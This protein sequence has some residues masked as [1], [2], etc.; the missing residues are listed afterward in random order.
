MKL[1]SM[2]VENIKGCELAACDFGGRP[3]TVIGGNNAHGKSSYL[4]GLCMALGGK[5]LFPRDPIKAG[6]E[7]ASIRIKLQPE[8]DQDA[9]LPWPCTVTRTLVRS[10]DGSSYTTMLEIESDDHMMAPS[11]QTLL[12]QFVDKGLLFDPLNFA[13]EK[14]AVQAQILRDL[15]GLDFSKLDAKREKLYNQRTIINREIRDIQG[16]IRKRPDLDMLPAEPIDVGEL[17]REIQAANAHNSFIQAKYAQ[18]ANLR[19]LI[20]AGTDEIARLEARIQDLRQQKAARENQLQTVSDELSNM[21]PKDLSE[22]TAKMEQAEQTNRQFHQRE[23]VLE[24]IA[25]RNH[26]QDQ[27]QDLTRRI[28]KIDREKA[29]M[30]TNAK[31]PIEGL[32]FGRDGIVFDGKSFSDL[33]SKEQFLCAVAI[34]LHKNPRFRVAIIR[35]GSLLDEQSMRELAEIVASYNG[36][37]LIERVGVEQC[38]IVFENGRGTIKQGQWDD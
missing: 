20:D 34:A 24:L 7:E 6:E 3:V 27:Q 26:K 30:A 10:R 18:Q 16:R 5:K 38:H 36:Q 33:S 28:K 9:I 15:V 22:I 21:V 14:P 12:D 37:C 11:P 4:D 35:D 1:I 13:Q 19:Q 23:E 8:G 31:W 29:E 25:E 2:R 32:G 17:S